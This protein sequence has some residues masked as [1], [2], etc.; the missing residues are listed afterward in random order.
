MASSQFAHQILC[1]SFH[2]IHF[3][4]GA[5]IDWN[6]L[7]NID[8]C[9]LRKHFYISITC[10]FYRLEIILERASI[11][12]WPYKSGINFFNHVSTGQ[13]PAGERNSDPVDLRVMHFFQVLHVYTVA[14]PYW[15]DVPLL[16]RRSSSD[17]PAQLTS[18]DEESWTSVSMRISNVLL[19]CSFQAIQ[20]A[21]WPYH[22]T[23]S[24]SFHEET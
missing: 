9:S 17:S 11:F 19:A 14:T 2:M 15:I 7:L 6:G 23:L 16:L 13:V 1:A 8:L 18:E 22:M 24:G 3:S 5:H 21:F 10:L 20:H 4:L 12:F